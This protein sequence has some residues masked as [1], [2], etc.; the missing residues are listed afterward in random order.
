[1]SDTKLQKLYRIA[2][3]QPTEDNIFA[4]VRAKL[5]ARQKPTLNMRK[6]TF[7]QLKIFI[8]TQNRETF[9]VIDRSQ[10]P[11]TLWDCKHQ[12]T[13]KKAAIKCAKRRMYSRI[14]ED[15]QLVFECWKP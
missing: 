2:I 12:H 3:T 5:R 6:F 10:G 4:L 8:L 1:M 7:T 9:H 11:E 14:I 15:P 13:S